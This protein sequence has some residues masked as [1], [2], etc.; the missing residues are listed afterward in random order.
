MIGKARERR[1]AQV[2]RAVALRLAPR[3]EAHEEE[4][5]ETVG[6]VGH[7]P[8]QVDAG[9][10]REIRAQQRRERHGARVRAHDRDR[11]AP[12][13]RLVERAE[14]WAQELGA[15]T[16]VVRSNTQRTESH[17]FYPALGF[18]NTKTQAVYRKVLV[19]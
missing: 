12:Q 6:R 3:E 1:H 7:V 2:E 9:L 10:R 5:H 19:G 15:Q 16:L 13:V 18:S 14:Q 17:R 4:I 11:R 8:H